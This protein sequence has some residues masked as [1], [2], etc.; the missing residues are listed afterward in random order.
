MSRSKKAIILIVEGITDEIVMEPIRQLIS[1]HK[2][3]IKVVH[4]DSYLSNFIKENFGLSFSHIITNIRMANAKIYLTTTSL[5]IN[6]IAAEL[7]YGSV[8]HFSR[9]FA[10]Y[11]NETPSKY[12]KKY[13]AEV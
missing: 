7:G 2:L 13:K 9:T 12:R 4:G 6:D 1:K 11:N 8:D 10:K 5:S 3:H